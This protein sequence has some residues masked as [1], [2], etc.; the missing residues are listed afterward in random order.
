MN[1]DSSLPPERV[2]LE[3]ALTILRNKTYCLWVGAGVTTHIS[4]GGGYT[5][6][7]WHELTIELERKANIYLTNS[8]EFPERIEAAQRILGHIDF[9]KVIREQVLVPLAKSIIS[10]AEKNDQVPTE[11]VQ[12]ACLGSLANHIV[13][14]NIESI[15]SS[16]IAGPGGAY[17][18][19]SFQP[20][21][22]NATKISSR[23]EGGGNS[24]KRS[25]YH[26]HGTIDT[27]GLCVLTKSDYESMKDT[28]ALEL[29]VHA[30]FQDYLAIVGMS[31]DDKYLRDQITKFRSYIRGIFWF[32]TEEPSD[33]IRQWV[34]ET[35]V[36]L[37]HVPSWPH[38]WRS[39]EE[40][41]PNPNQTNLLVTWMNTFTRCF[42]IPKGISSSINFLR[43]TF[44]VSDDWIRFSENRGES[45]DPFFELSSQDNERKT[46]TT[47]KLLKLI[48]STTNAIKAID[49]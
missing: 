25:V 7:G 30:A 18:I 47:Q 15:T 14:F 43:A 2:S 3:N 34:L 45:F 31:L 44:P 41:L 35:D 38:F 39:V 23:I 21:V 29:A 6:P 13:N 5:T 36:T 11:V 28:L 27:H 33:S 46:H 8:V 17:S 42:E 24:F 19:K 37:I 10:L 49:S 1:T 9:Q 48:S 20:P 26:P 22:I 12:V 40:Q 4:K 32:T 16:L